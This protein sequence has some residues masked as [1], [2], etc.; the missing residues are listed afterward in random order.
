[1]LLIDEGQ[2]MNP[3]MLDIFLKQKTP[4]IVVGDP[5]QQIYMFRGAVDA[6]KEVNNLSDVK[7]YYLLEKILNNVFQ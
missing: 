4:K 6:L 1:M 2:D 5:H 3:P 7:T